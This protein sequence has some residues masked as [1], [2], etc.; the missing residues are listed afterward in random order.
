M[1]DP[2]EV[3]RRH[4]RNTPLDP[5]RTYDDLPLP[6]PDEVRA[7]ID[8][9]PAEDREFVLWGA[10]ALATMAPADLDAAGIKRVTP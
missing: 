6:V 5:N 10:F 9:L 7:R 2:T 3:L 1:Q 4:L 8:A